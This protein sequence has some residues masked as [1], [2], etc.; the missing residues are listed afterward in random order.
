M[1][2]LTNK[3][4]KTAKFKKAMNFLKYV[5]SKGHQPTVMTYSTPINGPCKNGEDEKMKRR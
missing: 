3:L 4:C 2:T 1:Y 5:I